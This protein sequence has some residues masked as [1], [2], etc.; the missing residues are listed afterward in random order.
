MVIQTRQHGDLDQGGHSGK[1]RYSQVLIH[2]EVQLAE[3]V[4]VL[5]V[6]CKERKKQTDHKSLFL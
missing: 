5:V 2:S 3:F 4:N 1:R 6:E